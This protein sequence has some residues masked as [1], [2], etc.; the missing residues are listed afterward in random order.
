MTTKLSMVVALHTPQPDILYLDR[1]TTPRLLLSDRRALRV[2]SCLGIRALPTLEPPPLLT[3]QHFSISCSAQCN[4]YHG[5]RYF[6]CRPRPRACRSTPVVHRDCK[7]VHSTDAHTEMPHGHQHERRQGGR[8]TPAGCSLDRPSASCTSATY[9]Y[10]QYGRHIL[11]QVQ[12]VA[13]GQRVQLGRRKCCGT[14][15]SMQD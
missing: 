5:A 4:A 15:H 14:V 10:I 13:L 12:I 6:A 8:C 9:S 7:A 11:P 3:I 1:A 2:A